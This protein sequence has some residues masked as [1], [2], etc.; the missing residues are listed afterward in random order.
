MLRVRACSRVA[1]LTRA[2]GIESRRQRRRGVEREAE[3]R[4]EP[5]AL[6]RDDA[7][8]S[9]HLG[10]R[11][12]E[13]EIDLQDIEAWRVTLLVAGLCR[14]KGTPREIAL[15]AQHLEPGLGHERLEVAPPDVVAHLPD[16]GRQ[17]RVAHGQGRFAHRD[18][19]SAFAT[20]FEWHGDGVGLLGRLL[21]DLDGHFG[22]QPLAG[23]ADASES[24]GPAE[25]FGTD[26]RIGGERTV[27]GAWQGQRLWRCRLALLRSCRGSEHGRQPCEHDPCDCGTQ[28]R[29]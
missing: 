18:T 14:A 11:G 12:V 20:E 10:L 16:N 4:V 9:G 19:L 17:F 2:P 1:A 29:Q 7:G 5:G 13:R 27:D 8:C 22:V 15:I 23:D 25:P 21:L 28:R 6:G 24:N 3:K 26:G